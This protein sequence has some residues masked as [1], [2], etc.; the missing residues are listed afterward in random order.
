MTQERTRNYSPVGLKE[1]KAGSKGKQ[2]LNIPE[3]PH[4]GLIMVV[5][6]DKKGGNVNDNN[7]DVRFTCG[8]K[9]LELGS[10]RALVTVYQPQGDKPVSGKAFAL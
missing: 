2:E 6:F 1:L 10:T 9:P 4:G 5:P 8:R 3:L 7:N